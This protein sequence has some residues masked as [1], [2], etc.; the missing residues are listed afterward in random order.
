MKGVVRWSQA[1]RVI[2]QP[3]GLSITRGG[4]GKVARAS[5]YSP[6]VRELAKL[7]DQAVGSTFVLASAG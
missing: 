7:M 1:R 4:V 2:Q 5:V 3:S 6:T